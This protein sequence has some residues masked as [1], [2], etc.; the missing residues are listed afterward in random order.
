MV[1]LGESP[2]RTNGEFNQILKELNEVKKEMQRMQK[3]IDDLKQ[4]NRIGF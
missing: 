2:F 4:R 1:G 3:E